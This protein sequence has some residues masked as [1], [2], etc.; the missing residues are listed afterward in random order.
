ML[1]RLINWI[2]LLLSF[3]VLV[4]G[5]AVSVG[6]SVRACGPGAVCCAQP[7]IVGFGRCGNPSHYCTYSC[8][9]CYRS[10][11]WIRGR[12]TCVTCC[13][14]EHP[15]YC[16]GGDG[17]GGGGDVTTCWKRC[18]GA[19][20]PACLLNVDAVGSTTADLSWRRVDSGGIATLYVC[21]DDGSRICDVRTVVPYQGQQNHTYTATGL[22]PSTPYY[23]VIG[24]D[25]TGIGAC[26]DEGVTVIWSNKVYFTTTGGPPTCDLSDFPS[27]IT[28]DGKAFYDLTTGLVTTQ[29]PT[30]HTAAIQVSDPDGDSVTVTSL[31]ADKPACLQ[32]SYSGTTAQLTPQGAVTGQAFPPLDSDNACQ[33]RVR[34]EVEDSGGAWARARGRVSLPARALGRPAGSPLPAACYPPT[35]IFQLLTSNLQLPNLCITTARLARDRSRRHWFAL[36][37]QKPAPRRG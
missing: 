33:V 19:L 25:G 10:C 16:G 6:P 3:L 18:D 1:R 24:T 27:T 37:R 11:N 15:G 4:Q 34:A 36:G 17:G 12:W 22:Q 30:T 35:S 28:Y 23:A 14:Y 20:A 26:E 8:G 21:R 5:S 13:E 9:R 2:A 31:S 29:A 7:V 32:T